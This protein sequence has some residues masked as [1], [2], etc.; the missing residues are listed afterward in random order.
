MRICIACAYSPAAAECLH[1]LIK[2]PS[3]K[4]YVNFLGD[5][6]HLPFG[7]AF[8]F[9]ENS[10]SVNSALLMTFRDTIV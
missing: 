1:V 10:H 5:S 9:Y 7:R 4:L 2:M 8:Q 6:V 3:T